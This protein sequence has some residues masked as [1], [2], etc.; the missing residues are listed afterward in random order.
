MSPRIDGAAGDG[1][2]I[3][4]GSEVIYDVVA[5]PYLF[6]LLGFGFLHLRTTQNPNHTLGRLPPKHI[7][8][9]SGS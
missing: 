3:D 1:G 4:A 8:K 2:Y 5:E 6:W 7:P 9:A